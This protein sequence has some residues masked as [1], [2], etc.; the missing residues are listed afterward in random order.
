MV[1]EGNR[2]KFRKQMLFFKDF[3]MESVLQFGKHYKYAIWIRIHDMQVV[4]NN[5]TSV[6][7]STFVFIGNKEV[8]TFF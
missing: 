4:P 8:K 3:Q 1:K 7:K 2:D 5:I 6:F